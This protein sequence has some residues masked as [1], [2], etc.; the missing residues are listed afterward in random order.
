MIV[1]C[2]FWQQI[3]LK[4]KNCSRG[5][6]PF[7]KKEKKHVKR[8]KNIDLKYIPTTKRHG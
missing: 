1:L 3:Y 4:A 2:L 7:I 5:K 8:E 6:S